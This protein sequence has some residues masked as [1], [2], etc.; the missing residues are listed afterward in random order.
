MRHPDVMPGR[1]GLRA[2]PLG[3]GGVRWDPISECCTDTECLLMFVFVF[4]VGGGER[5]C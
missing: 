5:E 4:M 1:G 3:P 2:P